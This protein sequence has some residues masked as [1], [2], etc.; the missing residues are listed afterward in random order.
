MPA[1]KTRETLARQWELL[2][3]LPAIGAGKTVRQLT[4]ELNALSFSVGVRQIVR[5]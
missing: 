2:K 1:N 5:D 3:M 4:D